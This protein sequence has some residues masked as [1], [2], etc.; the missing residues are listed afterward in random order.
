[1][2]VARIVLFAV[3]ASNVFGNPQ[4]NLLAIIVLLLV[5]LVCCWNTGCIYKRF[6]AHI[7]EVFFLINLAIFT[8]ATSYIKAV[9]AST[10]KQE[11]G[12]GSAPSQFSNF[13]DKLNM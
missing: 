4:V 12:L 7:T 2:L 8:A 9:K 6:L 10:I 13:T 11:I 3:F 1:M 5:V